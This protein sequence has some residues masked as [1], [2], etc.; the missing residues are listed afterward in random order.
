MSGFHLFADLLSPA[1]CQKSPEIARQSP[2]PRPPETRVVARSSPKSPL[3]PAVAPRLR[4]VVDNTT[5]EKVADH[6]RCSDEERL[7]MRVAIEKDP[8]SA[9]VCFD[10][11][12]AEI[13]EQG[14]LT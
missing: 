5:F 1:D 9:V 6:Y 8:E 7:L 13:D 3:S 10:A 12:A 11:L 2:G 14:A 4:L